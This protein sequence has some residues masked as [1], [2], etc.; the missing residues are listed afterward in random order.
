MAAAITRPCRFTFLV[1]TMNAPA[2]TL[3]AK[4]S[5]VKSTGIQAR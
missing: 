5:A 1:T 3:N 4:N 2:I